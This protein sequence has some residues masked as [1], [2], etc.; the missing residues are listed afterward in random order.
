MKRRAFRLLALSFFLLPLLA[1]S[2]FAD[3]VSLGTAGSFAVLASS[4]VTNTGSSVV[5]NGSV[6][7]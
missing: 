1:L 5:L 7:V 4:A 3:S 2:A 6:G